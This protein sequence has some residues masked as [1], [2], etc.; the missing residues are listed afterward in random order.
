M[1]AIALSLLPARRR[2]G[3]ARHAATQRSVTLV[4]RR[5]QPTRSR[6][7]SMAF[8]NS[9]RHL[10]AVLLLLPSPIPSLELKLRL[11]SVP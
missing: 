7:L 11:A 2:R 5:S 1:S 10:A 4:A 8:Y 6:I 3:H 9:E